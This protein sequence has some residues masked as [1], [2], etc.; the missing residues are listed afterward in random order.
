MRDNHT[1]ARNTLSEI[2]GSAKSLRTR[3]DKRAPQ[4]EFFAGEIYYSR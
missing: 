1:T 2:A 4:K 3:T